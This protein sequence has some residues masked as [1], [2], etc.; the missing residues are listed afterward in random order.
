MLTI[1]GVPLIPNSF[2]LCKVVLWCTVRNVKHVATHNLTIVRCHVWGVELWISWFFFHFFAFWF[3]LNYFSSLFVRD[4]F[5]SVLSTIPS[6]F[7]DRPNIYYARCA[8]DLHIFFAC[9]LLL[10]FYEN[11]YLCIHCTAT[12]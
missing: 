1:T 6:I 10:H 12:G 11:M 3:F 8:R 7:S 2:S 9:E 4:T 5:R